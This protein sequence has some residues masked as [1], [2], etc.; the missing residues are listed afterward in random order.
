[1]ECGYYGEMRLDDDN[2]WY[3]PNCNNKDTNKMNIVR[4]TCG[5][6]GENGWN[7]GKTSEIKS[8]VIHLN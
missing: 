2:E 3:C 1:M 4:R 6:L 5:Y 7:K 8:R